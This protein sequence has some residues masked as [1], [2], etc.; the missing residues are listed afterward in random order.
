MIVLWLRSKTHNPFFAPVDGDDVGPYPTDSLYAT[1]LGGGTA[2]VLLPYVVGASLLPFNGRLPDRIAANGIVPAD[3][4][5]VGDVAIGMTM[6]FV[7]DNEEQQQSSLP[8][9]QAIA[10]GV[11][12][13]IAE[14]KEET[15][16]AAKHGRISLNGPAHCPT[17]AAL[18]RKSS[19]RGNGAT[20]GSDGEHSAQPNTITGEFPLPASTK[21]IED[22]GG[23]QMPNSMGFMYEIEAVRRLIAAKHYT[24]PQWTPEES[25]NCIKI[26]E[27]ILS[28]TVE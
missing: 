16:Y 28:Q 27:K 1:E 18:T 20:S 12:G 10:S 25:V 4:H 24:F 14:S 5:D 11:C 9:N 8:G 7:I 2:W 6:T 15:M 19:G 3:A 22:S 13:F 21:E 23:I 26:I 17:S